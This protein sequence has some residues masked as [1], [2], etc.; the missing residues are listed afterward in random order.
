M[1]KTDFKISHFANWQKHYSYSHLSISKC[2]KY[3]ATTNQ[4]INPAKKA[5]VLWSTEQTL[6]I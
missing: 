5:K 1:F 3:I 2:L 4:F 6:S